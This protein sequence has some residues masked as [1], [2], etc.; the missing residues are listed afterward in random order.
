MVHG[1]Q[2]CRKLAAEVVRR[3][4]LFPAAAAA[5][6]AATTT[7]FATTLSLQPTHTLYKTL[8]MN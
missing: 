3:V 8:H 1:N 7:F 5:A 4:H 6:A 2:V